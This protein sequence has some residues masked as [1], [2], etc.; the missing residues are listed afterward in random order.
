MEKITLGVIFGNR[1][2]FPSHLVSTARKDIAAV[3]EELNLD[4]VILDEKETVFGSVE[5]YQHSKACAELFAANRDRIDGILV[6]LPNFGDEKGI[7]DAIKLSGLRVPIMVQAYPDD[8][9][10]FDVANR[11]DA[12]CGKISVCNNLRQYGYAYTLTDLHTVHPSEDSFKKDLYRF[13]RVCKV[14]RKLENVRLG[15]VGARP[16]A[17]NTVRYSEKLLQEAGITVI[18]ADL[19]EI[20]GEAGRMKDSDAPV[21]AKLDDIRAY[22]PANGVPSDAVVRMAKFG[23]ALDSWMKEFDVQA[24]ALQCWNSV[25]KNFGINVC[26]LMSMMS[27][28]LMPS[29]CEV[30]VTGV[31]SMY[32][33]QLATGK[34]AALVDWNNNYKKDPDKCVLFHCG[35]WAKSFY[36]EARMEYANI[37][38]TTLG[39]ENTYGA[40]NGNVAA[41]PMSF[42]RV[43]TDDSYGIIR[44]YVGDGAFTDDPLDTFG[45]RAVVQIPGLQDL[46]KYVCKNGFEHHAAI[47]PA[48]SSEILAEA[49]ET[50][51]GWDVYKH[52]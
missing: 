31:L 44:A 27:E 14:V 4:A 51:K 29:A 21:K 13:S 39:Q 42:A 19:S 1:D 25:Q 3:F 22:L 34:P 47:T 5:N 40:I 9:E 38:A 50:Y 35:N 36:E 2:F 43:S 18:T 11:R 26:T 8:T 20:M 10:L 17:F 37:L 46:M 7:A 49:F 52:S 6:V 45:S 16:Q 28:S 12:Y 33:L 32:S 48:L 23:A 15:S 24:T 30:D 41:G